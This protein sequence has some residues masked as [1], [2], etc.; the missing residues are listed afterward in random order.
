MTRPS[1]H[2]HQQS[3]PSGR[4]NPRYRSWRGGRHPAGPR[5][6]GPNSTRTRSSGSSSYYNS[7]NGPNSHHYQHYNGSNDHHRQH[8]LYSPSTRPRGRSPSPPPRPPPPFTLPGPHPSMIQ[9]S[10]P[11]IPDRLIQQC[12]HPANGP[13]PRDPPG[14]ATMTATTTT[15]TFGDVNPSLALVEAQAK[16]VNARMQGV[17]WI[18]NVRKMLS[19]YVPVLP[20]APPLNLLFFRIQTDNARPGNVSRYWG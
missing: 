5:H 11:Y 10:R 12:F 14:S 13:K 6:D 2:S 19:L 17:M 4:G 18:E 8:Q 20:A 16:E 3:R 7:S 1:F 15:T 9:L